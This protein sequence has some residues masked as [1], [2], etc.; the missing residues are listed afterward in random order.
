MRLSIHSPDELIAA[1]PHLLGF[2][3]EESIVLV[4]LRADL[5]IARVDLPTTANERDEVWDAISGAF[6]RY[7]QPGA[8]VAIVCMTHDQQAAELIGHD[9]ATRLASIGIDTPLRLS[10]DDSHWYD[11]DSG[12]SGVQTEGARDRLAATTVLAGR[13]QPVSNRDALATSLVSDREP[14]A[15]LLPEAR[16]EIAQSTPRREGQWVFGRLQQFHAD[17]VRLTDGDAALLLVAVESIP[18]RDALWN[19]QVPVSGVALRSPSLVVQAVSAGR[20]WA[21]ISGSVLG[22][23]FMRQRAS[24]SSPR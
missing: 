18:M 7:V 4:P 21:P 20:S 3:A 19:G 16:E 22:T 6:S 12:D 23:S 15:H 8:S 5:P 1:I 24:T 17:G 11:F 2:K 13:A 9:F 10:A 14:V